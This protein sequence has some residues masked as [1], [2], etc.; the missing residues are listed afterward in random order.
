VGYLTEFHQLRKLCG[1]EWGEKFITF[2]K[3]ERLARKW[4]WPISR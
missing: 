4:P 2:S 1:I 3:F